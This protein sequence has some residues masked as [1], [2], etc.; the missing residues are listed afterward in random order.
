VNSAIITEEI[1]IY[2]KP[3]AQEV[4]SGSAFISQGVSRG[5]II[6][7]VNQKITFVNGTSN[8]SMGKAPM[9][10]S[11]FFFG[12]I[13]RKNLFEAVNSGGVFNN[14]FHLRTWKVPTLESF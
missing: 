10:I 8:F 14:F 12:K 11:L 2:W 7:L 13:Y 3:L 9:L 6:T 5:Q 1:V 4:R